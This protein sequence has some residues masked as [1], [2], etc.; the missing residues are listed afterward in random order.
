MKPETPRSKP[1]IR[2]SSVWPPE[3]QPDQGGQHEDR[4]DAVP[5]AEPRQ[6]DRAVD[7]HRDERDHLE[8]R[9]PALHGVEHVPHGADRHRPGRRRPG[10][11]AQR[12]AGRG[13]VRR[14]VG[15]RRERVPQRRGRL[16]GAPAALPPDR[17]RASQ[18][19]A[20]LSGEHPAEDH[21]DDE[22]A[23]VDDLQVGGVDGERGQQVLQQVDGERAE[24]RADQAAAAARERRAAEHDGRDAGE[25][26]LGGV[27]RVGRADQA[28]QRQAAEAGEQAAERVA[29]DPHRVDVDAAGERGRVVAADGVEQAAER[30]EPQG[31]PDQQRHPDRD[32]GA[33]DG[34]DGR[35]E[36][37]HPPGARHRRRVRRDEQV[38]AL[39]AE[40]HRERDDDRLD[41]QQDDEE[42]RSARRPRGRCPARS[43]PR[44]RRRAR[45]G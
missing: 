38:D 3:A 10:P 17:A 39:Q 25:R 29:R 20:A 43:A 19:A 37:P 27:G 1:P 24:Q 23:A 32:D 2:I 34:A 31:E 28:G 18:P 26:V 45:A 35:R 9:E 21:G 42:R 16:D 44:R 12:R 15:S 41:P 14:P 33:G 4:A 36:V 40:E 22:D 30:D 8:D 5:A 7:E 11:P 13:R 6:R